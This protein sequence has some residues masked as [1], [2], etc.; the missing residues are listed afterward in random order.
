MWGEAVPRKIPVV[1]FLTM[2]GGVGKTTLAA[3]ITRAIADVEK[4]KI[5]LIDTDAQCNLTQ[6]FAEP[7]E[8]DHKSARSIYQ[9]FDGPHLY[10]PDDLKHSI[11]TNRRNG[12]TIDLIF[13]SFETFALS[14][15]ATPTVRERASERF[16][17]FMR[18]A[19]EAYDLVVLDTNPS[20]TFTTMEALG[21]SNFLVAPITFDGFSMRGIHLITHTLRDRYEWLRNPRQNSHITKPGSA[22]AHR[23]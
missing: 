10:G 8:I 7:A 19:R 5:L 12:S 22:N 3:N 1:S 20:A 2:K 15:A 13:G 6:I 4:R 18:Q 11:Y 9:A 21:A 14:V 17:H 23:P 16:K